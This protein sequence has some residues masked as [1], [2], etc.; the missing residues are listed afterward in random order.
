MYQYIPWASFQGLHS[1]TYH[2]DDREIVPQRFL[3]AGV[4]PSASKLILAGPSRL[5]QLQ[6]LRFTY[7]RWL[8]L[9]EL[10]EVHLWLDAIFRYNLNRTIEDPTTFP[11]IKAFHVHVECVVSYGRHSFRLEEDQL[12]QLLVDRLPAIYGIGGRRERYDWDT[13][14]GVFVSRFD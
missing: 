10:M 11:S 12:I 6:D 4:N 13:S 3:D 2:I 9:E 1:F 7:D 8:Q 14:I 5:P